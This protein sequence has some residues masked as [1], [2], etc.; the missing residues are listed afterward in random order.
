MAYTT[1]DD[2]EKYFQCKIYTGN[3]STQ[4]ITFDGTSD[5][6]PDMN[7]TKVRSETGS[8]R[9]T[10][11]I[12]GLDNPLTGIKET[13]ISAKEYKIIDIQKNRAC[14]VMGT[15]RPLITHI[16]IGQD[17]VDYFA[18]FCKSGD[19]ERVLTEIKR[20]IEKHNS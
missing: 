1:I 19:G 13:L 9:L 8:H 17:P 10:D 14:W 4:S 5:M 2:P 3:G 11:I 16:P 6:R 20:Q 7:W 15:E 18:G 12:R